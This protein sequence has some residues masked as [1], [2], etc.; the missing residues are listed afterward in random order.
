MQSAAVQH[1]ETWTQVPSMHT[2]S[3]IDTRFVPQPALFGGAGL[4]SCQPVAQPWYVQVVPLQLAPRL[5]PEVVSQ[6]MPQAPQF[7]V[8][9]SAS[10]KPE[11]HDI[12]VEHGWL[13]S[14]PVVHWPFG[15]QTWVDGQLPSPRHCT[16]V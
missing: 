7:D 14:Q 8:V 16:H 12:P 6:V 10:Q 3:P 13:V 4:Q 9:S 11:Q 1:A 2:F 15:P 5:W